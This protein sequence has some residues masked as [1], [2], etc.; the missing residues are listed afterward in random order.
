M[1]KHLSV[2]LVSFDNQFLSII[3]LDWL[4]ALSTLCQ[5]KPDAI[6]MRSLNKADV[7]KF[8]RS[9]LTLQCVTYDAL[10]C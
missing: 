6:K 7:G 5:Q 8:V 9:L 4:Q 2:S 1:F 3:K 10:R